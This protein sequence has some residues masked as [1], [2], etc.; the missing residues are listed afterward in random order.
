MDLFLKILDLGIFFQYF[1]NMLRTYLALIIFRLLRIGHS[2]LTKWGKTPRGIWEECV[3][4]GLELQVHFCAF[5]SLCLFC[6]GRTLCN[7]NIVTR[8]TRV[9]FACIDKLVNGFVTT[10][11]RFA[12]YIDTLLPKKF[13]SKKFA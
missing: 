13:L 5:P 3:L 8:R 6:H 9:F 12:R 11:S 7:V 10:C 4:G 1:Y 2:K